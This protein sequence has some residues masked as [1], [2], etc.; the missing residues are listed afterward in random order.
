MNCIVYKCEYCWHKCSFT[1]KAFLNYFGNF[2]CLWT[3]VVTVFTV[4]LAQHLIQPPHHIFTVMSTWEAHVEKALLPLF[5]GNL[6]FPCAVFG[7]FPVNCFFSLTSIIAILENKAKTIKIHGTAIQRE[8]LNS[9]AA[10]SP[11]VQIQ[12]KA[13][14]HSLAVLMP[15]KSTITSKTLKQRAQKT[16]T[17]ELRTCTHPG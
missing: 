6:F 13:S 3:V 12:D 16:P 14:R 9:R 15:T 8:S 7:L 17:Q 4:I 10:H 5:L 1:N 2:Y 11:W